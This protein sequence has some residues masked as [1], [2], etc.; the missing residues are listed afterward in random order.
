M[1]EVMVFDLVKYRIEGTEIGKG[2][3]VGLVKQGDRYT[4]FEICIQKNETTGYSIE[5]LKDP[6]S[7]FLLRF[8]EKCFSNESLENYLIPDYRGNWVI[9]VSL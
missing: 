2:T 4:T 3:A 8:L 5:Y 6:K 9:V 7:D 1:N